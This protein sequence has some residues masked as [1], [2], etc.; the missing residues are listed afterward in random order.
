MHKDIKQNNE[1][2]SFCSAHKKTAIV[3]LA[4]TLLA[5]QQDLPVMCDLCMATA[6][7]KVNSECQSICAAGG[8]TVS[9]AEQLSFC[10]KFRA[11][12]TVAQTC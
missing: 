7:A 2:T 4:C 9:A 12:A 5:S 1:Q 10:T 8:A 11:D 3:S 6:N